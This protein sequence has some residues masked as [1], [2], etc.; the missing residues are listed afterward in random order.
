MYRLRDVRSKARP[1]LRRT[2]WKA[3]GA[4]K[5]LAVLARARE[6][7]SVILMQHDGSQRFDFFRSSAAKRQAY[8]VLYAEESETE[9]PPPLMYNPALF[10]KRMRSRRLGFPSPSRPNII[11]NVDLKT[12]NTCGYNMERAT[13][14][15]RLLGI[16]LSGMFVIFD[17]YFVGGKQHARP[18]PL[19]ALSLVYMRTASLSAPCFVLAH[20]FLEQ[21]RL[22]LF[23]RSAATWSPPAVNI[24]SWVQQLQIDPPSCSQFIHSTH[25]KIKP[26]AGCYRCSA[27]PPGPSQDMRR[28][29][30]L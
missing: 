24:M 10:S 13:S 14:R 25:F 23:L 1:L 29:P 12:S 9:G 19:P 17:V 6:R 11:A 2:F 26:S 20:L 5:V 15:K 3:R 8:L 21:H 18:P 30:P 7:A 28:P 22:Q 4:R 16:L 27:R